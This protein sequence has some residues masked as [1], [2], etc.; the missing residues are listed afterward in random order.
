M[1]IVVLRVPAG[2]SRLQGAFCKSEEI[3][4]SVLSRNSLAE[5]ILHVEK[6]TNE[7]LAREAAR[8]DLTRRPS[9]KRWGYWQDRLNHQPTAK[10]A[11]STKTICLVFALGVA[12]CSTVTFV[13]FAPLVMWSVRTASDEWSAPWP[14]RISLDPCM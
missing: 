12:D 4:I 14:C 7:V 10:L 8:M 3:S 6:A 5:P 9:M 13:P 1:C 11:H 2:F